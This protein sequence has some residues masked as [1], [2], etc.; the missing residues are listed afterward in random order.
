MPAFTLRQSDEFAAQL[1]HLKTSPDLEKRYKAVAKC[2][3]LL[4]E[5]PKHPSLNTHKFDSLTG[6]NGEEVFEAYAQNRTPGA[7]RVFWHY[8][9]N[10]AEITLISV[11]SHP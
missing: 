7:Y 9:P 6:A 10:K 2:I 3:R 4:A 1:D 8:G 5:N 11:T